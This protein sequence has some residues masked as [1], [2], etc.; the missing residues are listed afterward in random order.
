MSEK[1]SPKKPEV[2]LADHL[3]TVYHLPLPGIM[4]KTFY[5]L[6]SASSQRV[7]AL[8]VS[9]SVSICKVLHFFS[10]GD[11]KIVN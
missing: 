3:K 1:F 7:Y 2:Y 8:S 9:Q 6:G 4:V 11:T 5:L 10:S